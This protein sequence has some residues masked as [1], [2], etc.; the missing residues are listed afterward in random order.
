MCPINTNNDKSNDVLKP[1]GHTL[2]SDRPKATLITGAPRS[3]T[4]WIGRVLAESP[5]LYYIHEPFNPHTKMGRDIR[6]IPLHH[7]YTYIHDGNESE[8]YPGVKGIVESQYNWWYG[9]LEARSKRDLVNIWKQYR[10]YSNYRS[11]HIYP[12]IKDPIAIVSA[13]WIARRFDVNVVTM[14]RHPAAFV[15]SMK[16]LNWPFKPSNWALSQPELMRDYLEPFR[17]EMHELENSD[18]D[19]IEQASLLWKVLNYIVL[20]YK[21]EHKDWIFLRHED[22]SRDPVQGFQSLYQSLGLNFT[23]EIRQIV[24]EYSGSANPSTAEGESR[25]IK[26]NSKENIRN[27][28]KQLSSVEIK[29]VR[30]IVEDVAKSFYT[31]ADW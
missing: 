13:G 11:H 26:L 14:I 20:R 21:D 7:H 17:D 8:Y 5:S 25:P 19:I 4:T 9:I 22:I 12:L 31:D 18:S 28:E 15:A 10:T 1:V 27:W 24:E 3:G 29:R 16:R 2:G 6:N 23:Q 30:N